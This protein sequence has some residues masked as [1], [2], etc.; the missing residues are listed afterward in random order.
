MLQYTKAKCILWLVEGRV[1]VQ[2][3]KTVREKWEREAL[4]KCHRV[5]RERGRKREKCERHEEGDYMVKMLVE[6]IEREKY[7]VLCKGKFKNDIIYY[8]EGK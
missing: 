6:V 5:R 8:C 7:T 3:R 4:M 2:A 1:D